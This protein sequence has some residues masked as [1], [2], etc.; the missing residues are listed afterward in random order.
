MFKSGFFRTYRTKTGFSFSLFA[1]IQVVEL[2]F[3]FYPDNGIRRKDKPF[4][5]EITMAVYKFMGKNF[6]YD[7]IKAG[8]VKAGTLKDILPDIDGSWGTG[9]GICQDMAAKQLPVQVKMP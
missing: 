6:S 8:D 4:R 9:T 2:C 5:Y 3:Q 7:W 1:W